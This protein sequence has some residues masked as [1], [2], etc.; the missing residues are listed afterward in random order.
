MDVKMVEEKA[1]GCAR[2]AQTR[3]VVACCRPHPWVRIPVM[4]AAE[5]LYWASLGL[6]V[7]IVGA[8]MVFFVLLLLGPYL[9][10]SLLLYRFTPL[11]KSSE[12]HQST[13]ILVLVASVLVFS[14]GY[15]L[16]R[17]YPQLRNMDNLTKLESIPVVLQISVYYAFLAFCSFLSA[18][19]TFD[20]LVAVYW[21]CFGVVYVIVLFFQMLGL[22]PWY[23]LVP[24]TV[25]TPLF[26][27]SLLTR[28]PFWQAEPSSS[29]AAVADHD[30][31]QHS[32]RLRSTLPV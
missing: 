26:V 25:F 17:K 30:K 27:V 18:V 11:S 9:A 16:L 6:A 19:L 12:Q 4:A 29:A 13:G 20:F 3:F 10:F 28:V 32:L 7:M 14:G 1:I 5:A 2:G 21:A 15:R 22:I 23:V 24:F 8:F 31:F